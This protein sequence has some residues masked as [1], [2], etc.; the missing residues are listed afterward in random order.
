MRL[1]NYC[2]VKTR[3]ESFQDVNIV[4]GV[5]KGIRALVCESNQLS[6]LNLRNNYVFI[7]L[8]LDVNRQ[9]LG[10][11]RTNIETL[12]RVWLSKNCRIAAFNKQQNIKHELRNLN[13]CDTYRCPSQVTKQPKDGYLI[14]QHEIDVGFFHQGVQR[15]QEYGRL[16]QNYFGT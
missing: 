16:N 11:P 14:T 4:N 9:V 13:D 15:W 10:H 6:P 8:S 7:S 2:R 5:P 12:I 3:V 1:S